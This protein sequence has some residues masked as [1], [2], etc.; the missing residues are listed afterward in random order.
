MEGKNCINK[1]NPEFRK[2]LRNFN[3]PATALEH[4]IGLWQHRNN[5]SVNDL[6]SVGEF[7]MTVDVPKQILNL[8]EQLD[9]HLSKKQLENLL[10][11][12]NKT[13]RY[14]MVKRATGKDGVQRLYV[15]KNQ[16]AYR[17]AI[18]SLNALKAKYKNLYNVTVKESSTFGEDGRKVYYIDFP[19]QFEQTQLFFNSTNNKINSL[20][21]T[22]DLQKSKQFEGTVVEF[23]NETTS[24]KNTPTAL[25]N[26]NKGEKIQIVTSLMTQKYADKAWTNPVILKDGS[27]ANPLP[28]NSFESYDEFLTF[29]LLN[30]KAREYILKNPN[31]SLGN[32]ESRVNS[33]ALKRLSDVKTSVAARNTM[34]AP[35]MTADKAERLLYT[36]KEFMAMN[37][38]RRESL[39]E[40]INVLKKQGKIRSNIAGI[41][42]IAD[43]LNKLVGV[44][45]G[46]S[47]QEEVEILGE[48]VGH[49]AIAMLGLEHPLVKPLLDSIEGTE[50]FNEFYE[51]YISTYMSSLG[52]NRA[53]ASEHAKI[54]ILGK[55]LTNELMKDES[56]PGYKRNLAQKI[57]DAIKAFFGKPSAFYMQQRV[58]ETMGALA[59]KIK[60]AEKLKVSPYQN[61]SSIFFNI[62]EK[63]LQ[64]AKEK[65]SKEIIDSLELRLR[66]IKE[67]IG[68]GDYA[69]LEYKALEERKN[70]IES[71]IIEKELLG[72]TILYAEYLDEILKSYEDALNSPEIKALDS[73]KI[74]NAVKFL[75]SHKELIHTMHTYSE[76]LKKE[77]ALDINPDL[78]N[79]LRELIVNSSNKINHL[80]E[81]YKRLDIDLADSILINTMPEYT[82]G[83]I[84]TLMQD[85]Q[86]DVWFSSIRS[87]RNSKNI[88]L[89]SA[90]TLLNKIKNISEDAGFQTKSRLMNLQIQQENAGFNFDSMFE[91]DEK[92]ELTGNVVSKYN[93][94]K[95]KKLREEVQDKLVSEFPSMTTYKELST[96]VKLIK[97]KISRNVGLTAEEIKM[98]DVYNK[99]W[100]SFSKLVYDTSKYKL[101]SLNSE[102]SE[103][104]KRTYI[105]TEFEVEN[106][107]LKL[108]DKVVFNNED[109][110]YESRIFGKVVSKIG[111]KFSVEIL[112]ATEEGLN[113]K[114]LA[115]PVYNQIKDNPYYKEYIKVMEETKSNL[116]FSDR[117][118][119]NKFKLP[120]ISA[121][122]SELVKEGR[123]NSL[124]EKTKQWFKINPDDADYQVMNEGV[125]RVSKNKFVPIYYVN[126]VDVKVLSK[127]LTGSMIKF[128]KMAAK[129][130]A[131]VESRSELE[132]LQRAIVD[133]KFIKRKKEEKGAESDTYKL[134]KNF[135]DIYLFGEAEQ[136]GKTVKVGKYEVNS[137]KILESVYN[138]ISKSNLAFSV[139][140]A[141]GG[142]IKGNIDQALERIG[143]RLFGK[144]SM[145][146]SQIEAGKNMA[147][148]LSEIGKR[149][150]TNKISLIME[151][152][153]IAFSGSNE[154]LQFRSRGL[155]MTSNDIMYSP[156]TLLDAN[157]KAT[158]AIAVGDN[159][160]YINGDLYL[161]E[162]YMNTP[163]AT[164][165]IWKANKSNSIYNKLTVEKGTIAGVDKK[166]LFRYKNILTEL[167]NRLEG[168]QDEL[169]RNIF[170]RNQLTKFVGMHRGWLIN[171]LEHRFKANFKSPLTGLEE[172][173]TYRSV[174][175]TVIDAEFRDATKQL[176]TS[177]D[178]TLMKAFWEKMPEW[179]KVNLI[180]V[181]VDAAV[182]GVLTLLVAAI[183]AAAEDDDE[184][185]WWLQYSAYQ[186]SRVLMEQT[187]FWDPFTMLEIVKSPAAGISHV[188]DLLTMSWL[189]GWG[190]EVERGVYKGMTK[191][192]KTIIKRSFF[193]NLYEIQSPKEKNDFLKAQVLGKG[194]NGYGLAE[195][196]FED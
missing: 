68:K 136:A 78:L 133:S 76:E 179:K 39:N 164:E 166:D 92:G 56:S 155:R 22:E 80:A 117:T 93:H 114:V 132:S 96:K 45:E 51:P 46:L 61:P 147:E 171:G 50:E 5:K 119:S 84:I 100:G 141:V 146:Y 134:L 40:V 148:I 65:I 195:S 115:N 63:R 143:G 29:A 135:I 118:G 107:D 192:E 19:N 49:I 98:K 52:L 161:K 109:N 172:E 47:V 110:P 159:L 7:M 94:H 8:N 128:S 127:D 131:S 175:N 112:D 42:G 130:K 86:N 20:I 34:N 126:P 82:S 30:E 129:Y 152:S 31:E 18:L 149:E 89:R 38:I 41:A 176:F 44:Q 181:G 13:L 26:V 17:D 66:Q 3:L 160:R 1:N 174:V 15:T 165:E 104:L 23:L 196:F 139:P 121:T 108:G 105:G 71:Q 99:A 32:Y 77:G 28:E 156:Y 16:K 189:F 125:T 163:G 145:G 21:T 74:N 167:S 2:L 91:K 37:G 124:S 142:F 190:E 170:N 162:E 106:K 140:I 158:L 87:L 70:K 173:G 183:N 97:D 138:W 58:Q 36:L 102:A 85:P 53:E 103:I 185:Q 59:T 75:D 69:E 95:L 64:S 187:A 151:Y 73:T 4:R 123:Y 11:G 153:G 144:D 81:E 184:D 10:I 194:F 177:G 101:V 48:E 54:E 79:D 43:T 113:D 62:N 188:E 90:Y 25:R 9:D 57:W 180:K 35:R 168:Q 178:L 186:M 83:D 27:K 120:Q 150:K 154:L 12:R 122:Y 55:I 67:K 60:S 157:R 169:D 14:G 24:E 111:S 6:P 182:L 191:A 193:K 137:S 33:E 116:R 88:I 72:G